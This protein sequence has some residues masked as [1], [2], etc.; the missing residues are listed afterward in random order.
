MSPKIG[1]LS[2]RNF[3]TAPKLTMPAL[4]EINQSHSNFRNYILIKLCNLA[5][6]FKDEKLNIYTRFNRLLKFIK[7]LK[8]CQRKKKLFTNRRHMLFKHFKHCETLKYNTYFNYWQN[9]LLLL[10]SS[11]I[12]CEFGIFSLLS[13]FCVT[14]FIISL[15]YMVTFFK[16][17]V[18]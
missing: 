3:W 8:G 5:N 9:L 12:S 2:K 11:V 4:P 18:N 6:I 16:V 17:E 13:D 1:V 10:L 7:Y 15:T 14:I